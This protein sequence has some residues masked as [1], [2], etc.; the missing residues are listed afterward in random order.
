MNTLLLIAISR[1]KE[2]EREREKTKQ[3]TFQT[4]PSNPERHHSEAK[5]GLRRIQLATEWLACWQEDP[6]CKDPGLRSCD[7]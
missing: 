1:K 3:S 6:L 5:C 4:N 2:R 7:M